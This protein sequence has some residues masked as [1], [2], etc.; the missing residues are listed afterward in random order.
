MNTL[1]FNIYSYTN[2]G[3][4]DYN[5]DSCGCWQ[6]SERG[7]FVVADGLGGHGHGEVASELA[8]DYILS[9]TQRD[10]DIS[11]TALLGLMNSVNK[12]VIER[13]A[14]DPTLKNM[15]TTIA[16]GM[17]DDGIFKYFN[18]GDSRIYYFKNG[19]LYAQSKDHSVPQMSVDLGEITPEEIRY[20]DDRSKLLKVI[21]DTENLSIK[22][23]EPEIK[24]ENGDAF[25]ICSDGFWEYV[26]ETEMEFDLIKSE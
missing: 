19:C 25:L 1:N 11:D 12:A 5:E 20:S 9:E 14:N 22:K 17:F 13:Q 6:E 3:A 16:V 18:V 15:R 7:V 26:F 24:I 21:G 2:Q 23:I 4:R 10:F 8:V